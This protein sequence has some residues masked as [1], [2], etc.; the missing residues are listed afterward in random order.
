MNENGHVWAWSSR[1]ILCANNSQ[2]YYR[3]RN[4]FCVSSGKLWWY[5]NNADNAE[6]V[7][8]AG[9]ADVND[10][11]WHFVAVSVNSAGTHLYV[12][13][14]IDASSNEDHWFDDGAG[15]GAGTSHYFIGALPYDY[16]PTYYFDGMI[17]DVRI[18]D[19]GIAGSE[20]GQLYRSRRKGTRMLR[21]II[22]LILTHR[23]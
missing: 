3:S 19:R 20:I 1:S 11:T 10:N 5:V 18:Y 21:S 2:N 7:S 4:Y 17:D 14:G 9:N 15:T 22:I 23:A 13:G 12:D 6:L 8:L 16:M